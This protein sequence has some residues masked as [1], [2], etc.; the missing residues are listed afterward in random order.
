MVT[1]DTNMHRRKFLELAGRTGVGLGMAEPL[2]SPA[3]LKADGRA[4]NTGREANADRSSATLALSLN[5][6]WAIATDAGNLG[7]EQKW[8]LTPRADAKPARVPGVIQEVFPAYH[9]VV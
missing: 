3:V 1:E 9:G 2:L 7:R 5:D 4:Q 6:G 8:F